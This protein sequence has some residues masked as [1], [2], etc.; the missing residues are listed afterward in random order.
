MGDTEKKKKEK[1]RS[2][3]VNQRWREG[4]VQEGDSATEIKEST[5]EI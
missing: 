5:R 2:S 3:R 4:G 1:S